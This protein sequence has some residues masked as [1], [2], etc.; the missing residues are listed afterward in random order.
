[1]ARGSIQERV[2]K[3]GT[4]SYIAVI[5]FKDI[6]TG[7]WRHIWKSA[8][9][10]R[11][12]EALKT[13]L[14]T[15]V[16]KDNY[17]APTKLTVEAYLKEWLS[18]LPGPVAPRTV[19][20]Y[21]YITRIHIVPAF[22]SRP[23]TQLR[24]AQIQSLYSS[25]LKSG[26]APR[27]VQICHVCIHKALKA[28]VKTGLLAANPADNVTQVKPE[29]HEIK[30]L[31][32]KE[33]NVFLAAAKKTSYYPLF[34]TYLYTGFRRSELLCVR[35]CDVDLLGMTLSI[36]RSMEYIHGVVTFKAPKT[37]ASRRLIALTPKNCIVLRELR[38]AR[39]KTRQELDL[40]LT[41]DN[42]LV[43]CHEDDGT[44]MLPDT[45]THAWIKLVRRNGY[46]GV[47]LHDARHTHASLLLKQ[48]VHPKVVQERLGHSSI[49]TTLDT[50]SHTIPGMQKAAAVNFDTA[51]ESEVPESNSLDSR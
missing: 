34:F 27:T 46:Y 40:P 7:K 6:S 3:D 23:L 11:K 2:N 19:Q 25:L 20:L 33:V 8:P 44:P 39:D 30:T 9:S 47:R 4:T 37:K 43:F 13:K 48:G 28:A 21:E 10:I 38:D 14:L 50:Y 31:Q 35:W 42:D 17:T 15:E 36:N 32:E 45:V 18:G 26:L 12:A 41:T 24:P 29:R 22:G 5:A 16:S 51:M 1:M 49:S